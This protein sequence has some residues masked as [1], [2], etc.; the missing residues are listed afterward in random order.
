MLVRTMEEKVTLLEQLFINGHF[1]PRE[2][3]KIAIGMELNAS[4]TVL[5]G[6]LEMDTNTRY[7]L[8]ELYRQQQS[9]LDKTK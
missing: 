8:A 5:E 6:S 3:A 4:I 2:I 1:T 9:E 7:A